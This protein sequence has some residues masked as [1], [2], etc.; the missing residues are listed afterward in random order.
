MSH[1]GQHIQNYVRLLLCLACLLHGEQELF[2]LIQEQGE[3]T[4]VG[5]ANGVIV[6]GGGGIV[7]STNGGNVASFFAIEERYREAKNLCELFYSASSYVIRCK[8]PINILRYH[9]YLIRYSRNGK[10]G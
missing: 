1:F 9:S 5:A 4:I 10:T 2:V 8:P 6:A 7:I 3:Q